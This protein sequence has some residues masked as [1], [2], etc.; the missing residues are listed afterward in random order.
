MVKMVSP[1]GIALNFKLLFLLVFIFNFDLC[2]HHCTHFQIQG[3]YPFLNPL[4][5]GNNLATPPEMSVLSFEEFVP[6]QVIHFVDLNSITLI[7]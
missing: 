7:F 1:T 2:T 4:K 5:M 3:C 6:N